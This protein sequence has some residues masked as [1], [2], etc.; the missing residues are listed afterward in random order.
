MNRQTGDH[1][2]E[3]ILQAHGRFCISAVRN[4]TRPATPSIVGVALRDLQCVA[5]TAHWR[6]HTSMP[7]AIP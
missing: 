4:W 7:V 6:S 5:G 2:I 3:R 1:Q